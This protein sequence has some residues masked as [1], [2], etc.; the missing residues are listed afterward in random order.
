MKPKLVT[1]DANKFGKLQ[2]S[3]IFTLYKLK[4]EHEAYPYSGIVNWRYKLFSVTSK[5]FTLASN[6]ASSHA[7]GTCL[8]YMVPR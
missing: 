2:N 1:R 6:T 7:L 3:G 5:L 4:A 8:V